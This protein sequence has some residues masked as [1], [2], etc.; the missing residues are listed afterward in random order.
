MLMTETLYS[1]R[2]R[3]PAER[4]RASALV[5]VVSHR[6]RYRRSV[7]GA[8]AHRSPISR[9]GRV[10]MALTV[11]MVVSGFIGRY[12]YTALQRN[13]STVLAQQRVIAARN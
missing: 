5:A 7:S 11:L 8:D 10:T 3:T 2:K 13:R 4:C 1:I 6:Y 9:F 12:L